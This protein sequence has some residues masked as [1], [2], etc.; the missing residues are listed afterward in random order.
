[1]DIVTYQITATPK[2]A[3]LLSLACHQAMRLRI[4]Q[5]DDMFTVMRN[6]T[7]SY[8]RHHNGES[9]PIEVQEKLQELA[10]LCWHNTC[11]GYK[12]DEVSNG[13]WELY[14]LFRKMESRLSDSVFII[15]AEQLQLLRKCCE[16]AARL[17]AGQ[18][19]NCFIDELLYAYRKTAKNAE[20]NPSDTDDIYY[21]VKDTC[22]YLHTLCWG[23]PPNAN[24]GMNYDVLSDIWW[25]MY[26]VFRYQL[27]LDGNS[28]GSSE[29]VPTVSSDKPSKTGTEPLIKVEKCEN[30]LL[31]TRIRKGGTFVQYEPR[32]T[33][34]F[35]IVNE[36]EERTPSMDFCIVTWHIIDYRGLNVQRRFSMA[37]PDG[38]FSSFVPIPRRLHRDAVSFMRQCDKEIKAS[39]TVEAKMLLA[40]K[41]HS[42]L[43]KMVQA[44]ITNNRS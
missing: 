40:S 11:T 3:A 28:D 21:K 15:T 38:K 22:D 34:V 42:K 14:C 41:C 32:K 24:H 31:D 26:Q 19:D 5:L 13:S 43:V 36:V 35:M 9:E 23:L 8:A 12:F 44:R 39:N 6:F 4:G 16:Q 18:L 27:W 17:R 25:D 1:M 33:L 10:R 20:E 29:V 37:A 30:G 2:Q 7:D